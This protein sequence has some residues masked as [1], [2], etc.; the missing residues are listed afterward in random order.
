[1]CDFGKWMY[2][3]SDFTYI[4]DE[5]YASIR[6]KLSGF[7][8]ETQSKM[9][10][11]SLLEH[12]NYSDY[13]LE[14]FILEKG[15]NNI[16]RKACEHHVGI[17]KQIYNRLVCEYGVIFPNVL[18]KYKINET[19]K[20]DLNDKIRKTVLYKF[21]CLFADGTFSKVGKAETKLLYNDEEYDNAN[22][23][24]IQYSTI[25]DFKQNTFSGLIKQTLVGGEKNN[26]FHQ[27]YFKYISLIYNDFKLQNKPI[28]PFFEK[29]YQ[30]LLE[31][32]RFTLY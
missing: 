19:I 32:V 7:Q 2:C 30:E 28:A 25:F 29:K 13:F 17:N 31:K 1:M 23:F 14:R 6:E 15:C 21:G 8:T 3:F 18:E 22:K 26:I 24:S 5:F 27:N 9:F 16:Q 20:N 11:Q 10:F 4:E 12:L